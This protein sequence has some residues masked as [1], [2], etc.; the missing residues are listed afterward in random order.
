M[1]STKLLLP[2]LMYVAII[3]HGYITINEVLHININN[4]ELILKTTGLALMV[5]LMLY[6]TLSTSKL[7]LFGP[8]FFE[9]KA[10]PETFTKK[11]EVTKLNLLHI[12]AGVLVLLFGIISTLYIGFVLFPSLLSGALELIKSPLLSLLILGVVPIVYP[13]VAFVYS[14]RLKLNDTV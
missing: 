11:V 14:L 2:T 8:Y 7:M 6:F 13:I 9:G 3:S 1:K 4:T 10:L 5:L 12:C